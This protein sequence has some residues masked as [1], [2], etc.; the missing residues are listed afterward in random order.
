MAK[1]EEGPKIEVEREYNIPLRREWLKVPVWKRA[2]KATKA[3]REFLVKH[4]KS[5]DI[6]MGKAMNEYIWKRGMKSPPHHVNV[7]VTK[8]SEGVVRAE[9]IGA[10]IVKKPEAPKKGVEKKVE[11]AKAEEKPVEKKEEVKEEPK[12]E[13]KPVEAKKE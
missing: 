9:L 2:K 7:K 5:E 12:T 10:K 6:N 13:E 1:K 8:D 11:E 4:M 3:A